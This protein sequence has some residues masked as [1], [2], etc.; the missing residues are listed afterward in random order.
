LADVNLLATALLSADAAVNI[1][2]TGHFTLGFSEVSAKALIY[3]MAASVPMAGVQLTA[4]AF[5]IRQAK[6]AQLGALVIAAHADI[7]RAGLVSV[8]ASAQ[9]SSSAEVKRFVAAT[10]KGSSELLAQAQSYS[11]LRMASAVIV[12]GVECQ[13]DA[14][15][16][17]PVFAHLAA[18]G[19]LHAVA[20]ASE[21]Y[22]GEAALEAICTIAANASTNPAAFDPPERTMIRPFLEREMLRTF[23][24]REMQR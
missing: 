2:S 23:T 10:I 3:R 9:V 5:V 7:Q 16:V 24:N 15:C 1:A 13:I 14:L 11:V 4:Q 17:R 6:A 8:N 20:S 19:E 18:C 22:Y 12:C 21:H